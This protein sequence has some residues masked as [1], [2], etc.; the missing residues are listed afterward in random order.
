MHA[1]GVYYIQNSILNPNLKSKEDILLKFSSK[2]IFF[3]K[4]SEKNRETK[5]DII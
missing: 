3:I 2:K 4:W 5:T 1:M